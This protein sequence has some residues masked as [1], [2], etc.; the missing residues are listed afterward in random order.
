MFRLADLAPIGLALVVVQAAACDRSRGVEDRDLPGLVVEGKQAEPPIDVALATKDPVELGR[1]MMR[2]YGAVL[3]AL[4]PH[5]LAV[6]SAS[7]VEEAGKPVSELSD[8]A[9]I[10]NG[11]EGAYRALYTNSADYGRETTFVNGMLYLRPRYQRWHGRAPEAADEPAALRDQ[12]ADA[13]A[14]TWDLLA[15]AIDVVDRGAAEVSGRAGRKIEIKRA[16]EPRAPDPEPLAQRKWR[17]ARSI[18]AVSGEIILDAQKGVPLAVQLA[19]TVAFSRDGRRFTMKI[20]VDSTV[21][22]LGA[23]SIIGA[24][25]DAEI[26][27]TPERAREVDDRDFLLQGIAPPLRRNPDGTPVAPQPR[28]LAPGTTAATA[29][30]VM[31]RPGDAKP[32]EPPRDKPR[33]KRKASSDDDKQDKRD[34]Q[35]AP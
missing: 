28:G 19:G 20:A 6:N 4:G 17:E 23:P 7:T 31:A 35:D 32:A 15:P 12:Y 11:A 24:P 9:Q 5:N 22:G 16:S 18:E 1:A 30:D 10:E 8:H 29:A 26:V 27:A 13:V 14:A 25:T 34:K 33:K 3:G 2:P 21:S